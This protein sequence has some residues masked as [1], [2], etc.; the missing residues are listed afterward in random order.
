[1]QKL[2]A[3]SIFAT[4]GNQKLIFRHKIH[5]VKE[6]LIEIHDVLMLLE[7]GG[8]VRTSLAEF[9]PKFVLSCY[10]DLLNI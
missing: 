6:F 3:V 10:E 4:L 5:D 9:V 7:H 1:M 2:L 8:F